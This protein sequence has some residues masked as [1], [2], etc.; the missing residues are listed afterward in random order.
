MEEIEA[1]QGRL[2]YLQNRV[3]YSMIVIELYEKV[4]YKEEPVSYEKSFWIQSKEG[5]VQGWELISLIV[6][7]IIN[8]WPVVLIFSGV[9]FWFRRKRK[10]KDTQ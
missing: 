4:D 8:I 1:A 3:S 9:V 10:K 5:F 2:K 6:V 7:G